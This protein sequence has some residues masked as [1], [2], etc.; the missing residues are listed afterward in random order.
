MGSAAP[1]PSSERT[2]STATAAARAKNEG[3]RQLRR[4]AKR[5]P[6][7]TW[8]IEGARGLGA[9]LA[10]RLAEDGTDAVDVPPKLATRVRLVR[11]RSAHMARCG[12]ELDELIRVSGLPLKVPRLGEQYMSSPPDPLLPVEGQR[13][14]LRGE[15]DPHV[16]VP[17]EDGDE[18]WRVALQERG[19]VPLVAP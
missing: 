10:T 14:A 8:A 6:G 19:R 9:P 15:S 5:W 7:A 18:L 3:Y 17:L 11:R 2:D 4:F 1:V 13:R 12:L 16:G